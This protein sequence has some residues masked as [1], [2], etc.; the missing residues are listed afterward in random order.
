MNTEST[1]EESQAESAAVREL[2]ARL[3]EVSRELQHLEAQREG[4]EKAVEA[5]RM[6]R[7]ALTLSI[8]S[9]GGEADTSA[10]DGPR[11]EVRVAGGDRPTIRVIANERAREAGGILK[12]R[13]LLR[14]TRRFGFKSDQGGLHTYLK[15]LEEF[16][17]SGPGEF[18]L[19]V[20]E[21]DGAP[22]GEQAPDEDTEQ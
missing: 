4:I 18:S 7:E 9:L 10:E 14:E 15:G 16:I 20:E 19:R 17:Q 1:A 22:A 11:I 6:E 21:E 3:A 12:I 13:D 2:R 8:R 5:K